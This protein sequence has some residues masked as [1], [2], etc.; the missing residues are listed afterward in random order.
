[1]VQWPVTDRTPLINNVIGRNGTGLAREEEAMSDSGAT[2]AT[3]GLGSG[4]GEDEVARPEA[5]GGVN[6][7]GRR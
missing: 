4:I 6:A 1:M 3:Y 2:D 7:Q 5:Q